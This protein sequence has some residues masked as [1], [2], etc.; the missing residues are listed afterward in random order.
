M[1]NRDYGFCL[2]FSVVDL[3]E[4]VKVPE[5]RRWCHGVINNYV[6]M[7]PYSY[8][9]RLAVAGSIDQGLPANLQT[10]PIVRLLDSAV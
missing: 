4:K 9:G 7:T 5:I 8:L 2:E 6:T 10:H 1:L 3:H